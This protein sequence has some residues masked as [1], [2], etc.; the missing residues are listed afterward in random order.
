[1]LLT[2][3]L[4][5]NGVIDD[6][7]ELLGNFSAQPDPATG[8]ERN[9]FSA[10]TVYDVNADGVINKS[11]GVYSELRLWQDKNHNAVSES[12]ELH[13]LEQLGLSS[14]DLKYE[15]TK[16]VDE[17]GN[18]FRYRGK[19]RDARDTHLGRWAWDVFLISALRHKPSWERLQ[20]QE[21]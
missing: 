21:K 13:P 9:G 11:D 4:N 14:L 3:D 1:M 6:G 8:E 16:K 15:R 20:W 10:L 2:L 17:Y 18:Q 7:R 5:A 19:V 12:D